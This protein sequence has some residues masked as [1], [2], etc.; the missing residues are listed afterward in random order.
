[1]CSGAE[2]CHYCED[3]KADEVEHLLPK[4]AYIQINVIVGK[5]LFLFLW[6]LQWKSD[7]KQPLR[8]C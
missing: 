5:N 6:Q 7:K 3:S 8:Y 4:D 1:M 2:R